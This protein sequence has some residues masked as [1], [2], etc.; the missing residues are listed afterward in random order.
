MISA[1]ANTQ[2]IGNTSQLAPGASPEPF[3]PQRRPI[4]M[5]IRRALQIQRL[6]RFF[7]TLLMRKKRPVVWLGHLIDAQSAIIKTL[8]YLAKREMAIRNLETRLREAEEDDRVQAL[9]DILPPGAE[10]TDVRELESS[11]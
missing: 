8:R 9:L 10:V 5:Q 4:D 2:V 1:P 6:L 11:Q 7:A 3:K